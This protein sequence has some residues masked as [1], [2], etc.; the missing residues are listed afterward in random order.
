MT[1]VAHLHGT[2]AC[3]DDGNARNTLGRSV[4]GIGFAYPTCEQR[5]PEVVVLYPVR[6]PRW[7]NPTLIMAFASY[8]RA[9]LD[10]LAE[11]AHG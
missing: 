11:C 5:M 7:R 1:C 4:A 8:W 9:N 3:R 6:D 2:M 10:H